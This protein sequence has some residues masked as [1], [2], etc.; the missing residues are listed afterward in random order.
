MSA[1]T[2]K[3]ARNSAV[4]PA[5]AAEH[6][7]PAAVVDVEER[8]GV[9]AGRSADDE[10]PAEP[11]H[12]PQQGQTDLARRSTRGR[13]PKTRPAD[14][15]Q[16][17]AP[18]RAAAC[19]PPSSRRRGRAAAAAATQWTTPG[20]VMPTTPASRSTRHA[21][22]VARRVA[23]QGHRCRRDQQVALDGEVRDEAATA[24][25]ASD[26]SV[27]VDQPAAPVHHQPE[28]ERPARRPPRPPWS[29][30]RSGRCGC[31]T[32]RSI[33]VVRR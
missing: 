24:V 2:A 18:P 11:R 17:R 31:V 26:G 14:D 16:Q 15:R 12:R 33:G 25:T 22:P 32:V 29:R 21:G 19:P 5:A 30:A 20:D 10:G 28:L 27:L 3:H 23:G 9:P 1:A 6:R 7:R 8:V 13:G 4:T